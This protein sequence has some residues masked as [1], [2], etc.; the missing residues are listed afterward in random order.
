MGVLYLEFSDLPGDVIIDTT[1]YVTR[2]G[3]IR[4]IADDSCFALAAFAL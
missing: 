1:D 3:L 2:I 4:V